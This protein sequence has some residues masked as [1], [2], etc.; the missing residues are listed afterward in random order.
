MN[1]AEN[2]IER[3]FQVLELLGVPRTRAR[4]VSN[5]IMVLDSRTQKEIRGL[6]FQIQQMEEKLNGGQ[7]A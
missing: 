3:S 2:D 1:S 6:E 5:G 4:S 7:S